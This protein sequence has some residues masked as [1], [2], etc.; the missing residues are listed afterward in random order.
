MQEGDKPL[1]Q[2]E[3]GTADEIKEGVERAAVSQLPC[4]QQ[5]ESL[6]NGSRAEEIIEIGHQCPKST[7]QNRYNLSADP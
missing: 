4:S 5:R 3:K 7:E 6:G 2:R 1:N